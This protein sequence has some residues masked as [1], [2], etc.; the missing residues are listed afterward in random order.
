MG[1]GT[2]GQTRPLTFI[3]R[4]KDFIHYRNWDSF[5]AIFKGRRVLVI[6]AGTSK[7]PSLSPLDDAMDFEQGRRVQSREVTGVESGDW[8]SDSEDNTALKNNIAQVFGTCE[9]N[10]KNRPECH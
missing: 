4:V 2:E 3:E 7:T 1:Q 9:L 8:K 6:D 10:E 5:K